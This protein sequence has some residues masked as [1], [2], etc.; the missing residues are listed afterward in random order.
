M[1][2]PVTDKLANQHTIVVL[3]KFLGQENNSYGHYLTSKQHI[4]PIKIERQLQTIIEIKQGQYICQYQQQ[5]FTEPRFH[6]N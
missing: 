5:S 4:F 6:L 2:I 1:Q 3:C